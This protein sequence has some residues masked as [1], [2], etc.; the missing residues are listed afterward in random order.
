[1]NGI[2]VIGNIAYVFK[3]KTMKRRFF[4]ILTVLS[5]SE[6]ITEQRMRHEHFRIHRKSL[7]H[8]GAV[9]NL[10]ALGYIRRIEGRH[11]TFMLTNKGLTAVQKLDN[12]IEGVVDFV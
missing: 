6:G 12:E 9:D 7:G 2:K 5:P 11:V 4:T 3:G 10:V 1:V 8:F